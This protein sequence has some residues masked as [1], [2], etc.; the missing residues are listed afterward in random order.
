MDMQQLGKQQKTKILNFTTACSP[1]ASH[2]A[3]M[4]VFWILMQVPMYVGYVGRS[5]SITTAFRHT[6]GHTEVRH[7]ISLMYVFVLHGKAK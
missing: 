3:F 6:S 5:T 7:L 4:T 2:F 1:D